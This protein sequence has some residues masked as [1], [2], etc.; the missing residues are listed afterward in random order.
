M[1]WKCRFKKD[2]DKA[3]IGMMTAEYLDNKD[4]VLF[5]ISRRFSNQKDASKFIQDAKEAKSKHD[6]DEVSNSTIADAI[7]T[8]LN[9]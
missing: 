5:S 4:N 3:D 1:P 8:E 9:K 7:E 6:A 2:H